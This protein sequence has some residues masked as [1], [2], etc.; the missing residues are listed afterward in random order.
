MSIR[1]RSE[2]R[3]YVEDALP[4]FLR[5]GPISTPIRSPASALPPPVTLPPFVPVA[6]S[7]AAPP[8]PAGRALV[9]VPERPAPALMTDA[10]FYVRLVALAVALNLALVWLLGPTPD[11]WQSQT[12][13]LLQPAQKNSTQANAT[14]EDRIFTY[15]RAAATAGG[16]A[17]P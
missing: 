4:R 8:A 17:L 1:R 15:K 10:W 13:L 5:G 2:H 3:V 6:A 11:H 9:V 12:R 7:P 14:L 16:S